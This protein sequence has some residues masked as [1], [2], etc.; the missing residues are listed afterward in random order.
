MNNKKFD[1]NKLSLLL[2]TIPPTGVWAQGGAQ[3][4]QDSKDFRL[5]EIIVTAEKR[6]QNMQNIGI[7]LSVFDE[8]SLENRNFAKIEDLAFSIPN[9][10]FVQPADARAAQVTIRG[11]TGDTRF[12][13][14]EPAV[15]MFLDG[16]YVSGAIGTNIELIDIERIEVLRGPQGTLYGRNTAAGAVNIIAKQPSAETQAKVVVGFGSYDEMKVRASFG[17]ALTEN[18]VGQISFAHH[19]RDGLEK[20]TFLSSDINTADSDSAR[21]AL[22]WQPNSDLD[23]KFVLDYMNEN[24]VPGMPDSTP[25]DREDELNVAMVEEREVG[26]LNLTVDYVVQGHELT[27][28][29]AYRGYDYKRLGD[30]DGTT[31]DALENLSTEESQQFSQEIRIASP[32]GETFDWVAGAYYLHSNLDHNL[33]L[34]IDY[35]GMTD[36]LTGG[37]GA[38]FCPFIFGPLCASSFEADNRISIDTDAAAVFS[39]LTYHA[40]DDLDILLGLRYSYEEKEIHTQQLVAVPGSVDALDV[41]DKLSDDAFTPKLAVNYRVQEN[42]LLY[43]SVSRGFKSA[44]FNTSPLNANNLAQFEFDSEQ[45]TNYEVGLKSELL[46]HRLQLNVAGFYIDYEDIQVLKSTFTGIGVMN[47]LT[48]AADAT[49]YGFE[50][51]VTGLITPNWRL[52]GSL[53]LNKA[54]FERYDGCQLDPNTLGQLSCSGNTLPT[55]PKATA[56]IGSVYTGVIPGAELEFTLFGEWAYRGETYYDVF[57]SDYAKQPGYSVANVSFAITNAENSWVATLW[58]KNLSDKN[59]TTLVIPPSLE[60]T[61]TLVYG[62]PRTYGVKLE[63][64]F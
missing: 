50:A 26:G 4:E 57:N 56:S 51:D 23:V 52:S 24:R 14:Q 59:Y 37:S 19:V 31:Y 48:N 2:L 34:K 12:A 53:G 11:I 16:A 64:N 17:G 38:S 28:I 9:F 44:G 49:S 1:M 61:E 47:S 3:I 22:R 39:Q 27:S 45:S 54:E 62:A 43:G 5:E 41:E 15:G 29:T 60:P 63:V 30:D 10:H 13:G 58:G 35:V 36:V 33:R 46:N 6:S 25:D 21:A 7:A 32:E 55:A 40:M 20:N 18:L 8:S 42:V